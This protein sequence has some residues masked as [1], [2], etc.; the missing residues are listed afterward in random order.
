MFKSI[1]C[2]ITTICLFA[3]GIALAGSRPTASNKAA[4]TPARF[5]LDS[6]QSKF[7]AH[8]QRGG[9]FW[10]K[11]HE[12]LI[13][14]RDFTGEAQ[15]DPQNLTGSSLT[16]IVKTGSMEETSD[17]FTPAQKQIINNELREIVLHP[18]KYPE[19]IFKS[20]DV[21]GRV[22]DKNYYDLKVRGNLTL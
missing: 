14:A 4:P 17:A 10:F 1:L 22:R 19:I 13:A 21:S 3:A 8:G 20:T 7:I 15:F 12:H 16:L 2:C 5:R 9:L 18:E 6:T 11:G